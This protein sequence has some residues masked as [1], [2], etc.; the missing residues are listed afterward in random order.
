MTLIRAGIIAALFALAAFLGFRAPTFQFGGLGAEVLIGGLVLLIFLLIALWKIELGVMAIIATAFLVRFTLPTGTQSR[1]PASLLLT[2]GML[3]IWF[4]WMAVK[5][6]MSFVP[7]RANLPLFGFIVVSIFSLPWSWLSWKPELF[8]EAYT[9]ARFQT[10]QIGG[11]A[12]MVLLPVAFFL[13][14]NI[15][16][17]TKWFKWLLVAMVAIAV[18]ELMQRI[19]GHYLQFAGLGISGPGLYH[20]WLISL[21]YAQVLFNRQLSNTVRIFF[22]LII[23]GWFVYL[24]VFNLKWFSGWMTALVAM[25]FLSFLKSKKTMLIWTLVLLIPFLLA[26]D[27][28]YEHIRSKAQTDDWNRFTFLWPTIIFDLTLTRAG[29]LFGAGPAGY[30]LYFVAYYPGQAMSAHN[31]Y[32]DIIAETGI[33]GTF[34]FLWFLWS[35][36]RTG[37]EQS[38]TVKDDFLLAFNNGVLAGFVAMIGAMMLDDWFI[39]F[40][41]NN[42][43]PGFDMNVYAFILLGAMVGLGRI[44]Q[45]NQVG[46]QVVAARN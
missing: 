39:P 33:V 4:I 13:G 19:S 5:H 16:Q 36:F 14:L 8:G 26:A 22:V 38:K 1:I 2:A 44:V 6:R 18:P 17:D 29:A 35:V 34:F 21:L 3:L 32:V 40:A 42:G 43:L 24:F 23:V 41:Y 15:L 7:S 30:A 28:Y 11:L 10:T 25:L 45:Q 31:N 12:V 37:W 27:Y 20:L 46:E 9:V